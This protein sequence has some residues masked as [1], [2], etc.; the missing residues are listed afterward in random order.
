MGHGIGQEFARAGFDVALY[1]RSADGLDQALANIRRNLDEFAAWGLLDAGDVAPILSRIRTTTSLADALTDTDLA[2]EAV[3]ENLELKERLF[4]E[5]DRLSPPHTILASNTSSIMPTTLGGATR[6]PGQVLVAHFSYPPHL[7][8]LVE[9]VRGR[10]T[11]DETV[12]SVYD[13]VARAGKSPIILQREATG[14]IINRMQ[15]A[16]QREALN[17]VAQ[18]IASAQDVDAA[19]KASFGR[20]LGVAGPIEMVEVQDGWDITRQIHD[21]ILPY[22]DTSTSASPMILDQVALG[23]LGPKTGRGFYE[24]TQDKVDAWNRA[25]NEALIRFLVAD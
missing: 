2:I 24:W 12:N 23:Q 8:P 9:I 13:A 17:I 19:V 4:A 21:Y 16:L 11:T 25:L 18:G 10:E 5:M 20:R 3:P 7:I 6:R 1:R 22:L 15:A 14:F